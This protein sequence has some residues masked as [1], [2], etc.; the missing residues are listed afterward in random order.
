MKSLAARPS[1]SSVSYLSIAA[2]W[3]FTNVVRSSPS[4]AQMPSEAI[5]TML[6]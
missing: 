3:G 5:S 4:I 6:R 1:I 2:I